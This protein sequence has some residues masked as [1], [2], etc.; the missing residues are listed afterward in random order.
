MLEPYGDVVPAYDM[1]ESYMTHHSNRVYIYIVSNRN[2]RDNFHNYTNALK[3]NSDENGS[4]IQLYLIRQLNHIRK[5]RKY[6]T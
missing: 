1:P 2:S 4:L 5:Q 3:T 6:A